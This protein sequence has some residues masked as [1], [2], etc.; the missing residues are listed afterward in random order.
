MTE[1]KKL[2]ALRALAAAG[3]VLIPVCSPTKPHEHYSGGKLRPCKSLG[4][5]P[6][7]RAWGK[8]PPGEYLPERLAGGNYGVSLRAGDL[9]IDVDPMLLAFRMSVAVK[10][11]QLDSFLGQ[12][13]KL[14]VEFVNPISASLV[15]ETRILPPKWHAPGLPET[16][17]W[18]GPWAPSSQRRGPA[19][20]QRRTNAA[21][22]LPQRGP[23]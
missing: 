1:S 15:G 18:A 16:G 2:P 17:C 8:V 9:I 6:P 22:G 11:K 7:M 13:Q 5:V 20:N 21:D 14:S 10:E 3:Y 23:G 12:V 4:K 19:G